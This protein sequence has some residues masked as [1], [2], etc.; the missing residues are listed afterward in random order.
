MA[1][2]DPIFGSV[3][4]IHGWGFFDFLGSKIVDRGFFD[5]RDRR[6]KIE[7]VG[8]SSIFR[9]RRS[10]MGGVLRYSGSEDRR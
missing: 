10:K 6:S 1:I 3:D 4:R 2:F 5:L 7:D 8:N 9:F